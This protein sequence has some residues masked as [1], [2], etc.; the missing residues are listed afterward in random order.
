MKNIYTCLA[1][2]LCVTLLAT[3]SMAQTNL[4]TN[5]DLEDVSPNFWEKMGGDSEMS[6]ATDEAAATFNSRRSFKIEK[7]SATGAAMGWKSVN[8]AD[9]YWNNAGSGSYWLKFSAKTEGVN[10]SPANDDARIGVKFIFKASNA[11]L[12]EKLVAVDQGSA[13][14]DW[15]TYED[16]LLLSGEPDEVYAELVMGK[17]ATGT[18][19]F[20]NVDCN[21]SDS[22]TMGIFNADAEIPKGWM[23][24]ASEGDVGFA[25]FVEDTAAHS[26]STSVLLEENDT[27]GDEMVFYSQPVAA[28]PD[29][30]YKVSVW[31]KTAGINTSDSLI[32]SNPILDV[33]Q[34]FQNRLGVNFFFHKAQINTSWDLATGGDRFMYFNQQT[35]FE[36]QDWVQY[37]VIVQ[38][39]EDAAGIS[40][41]ARFNPLATGKVWYDDFSIKPVNILVTALDEPKAN[42]TLAP[43]DFQ[44]KNN[45]PNPFN[46]ETLIE[47]IVPQN[48]NVKLVIYNILGQKV[49]TLVD[50]HQTTGTYTVYWNGR[51]DQDVALSSGVYFYQ[52]Q[53]E[54]ALITKKMTLVK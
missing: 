35:G 19:W 18:V 8:N 22:W 50:Q 5:G 53:G 7:A 52:L 41:R 4:L 37:N 17:D 49:R 43:T 34:F 36:N 14:T 30:W 24:W 27:N 11:T 31:A 25:N 12:G 45:Y 40:M 32:A 46:P 54:N 13:S 47:Y 38:A 9:L 16:A 15:T 26:G 44:L 6:W 21:T 23:N 51:N 3:N 48:G 42:I 39:P 28:Q 29:K 10:T 1:F 33:D 20:D 2:L